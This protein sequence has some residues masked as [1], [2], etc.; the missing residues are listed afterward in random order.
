[1]VNTIKR[2]TATKHGYSQFPVVL[3]FK[4]LVSFFFWKKWG[5][6]SGIEWEGEL[7]L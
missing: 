3:V 2:E 4:T 6:G 5:S 7:S 1:M